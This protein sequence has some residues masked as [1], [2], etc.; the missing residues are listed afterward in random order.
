MLK[1]LRRGEKLTSDPRVKL[2]T[3]HG[4]KGGEA[5]HVVLVTDMAART[6]REYENNPED[7]ARVWYVASTRA[8]ERLSIVAPSSKMHYVV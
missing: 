1:A 7:E 5:T 4:S 3:I 8:K 6:Y 2:S